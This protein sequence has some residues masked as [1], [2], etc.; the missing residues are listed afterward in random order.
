MFRKK[1]PLE[2]I[3]ITFDPPPDGTYPPRILSPGWTTWLNKDEIP[4]Q[5]GA[6]IRRRESTF[7]LYQHE[8]KRDILVNGQAIEDAHVLA[9]ADYIHIDD[10]MGVYQ[11]DPVADYRQFMAEVDSQ[12]TITVPPH[13]TDTVIVDREGISLN[14]GKDTIAWLNVARI[15]TSDEMIQIELIDSTENVNLEVR[16]LTDLNQMQFDQI[17]AFLMYNVP[18][19]ISRKDKSRSYFV[20]YDAF[21]E[22]CLS[23]VFDNLS[24]EISSEI[25]EELFESL[26]KA[27]SW[28]ETVKSLAFTFFLMWIGFS[29][30]GLL[31]SDE[32]SIHLIAYGLFMTILFFGFFFL[33]YLA[34][35]C[36]QKS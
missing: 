3:T 31:N 24:D 17:M 19:V 16:Q 36:G 21:C 7:T 33:V 6:V 35:R 12:V 4:L 5:H 22:I 14:G 13:I 29:F 15:Y 32:I 10:F 11:Q 28:Y 30:V 9:D 27:R 23:K 1:E 8:C 18:C 34:S 2:T 25:K 20:I 26:P